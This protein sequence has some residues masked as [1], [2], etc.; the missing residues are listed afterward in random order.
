MFCDTL[1]ISPV[2][3]FA[4]K[5]AIVH[6]DGR[7]SSDKLTYEQLWQEIANVSRVVREA[8]LSKGERV[9]FVSENHLHWLPIFL[10]IAGA[11]AIAVPVDG[12]IAAARYKAIMADCQPA[13]IIVSRRFESRLGEFDL[14]EKKVFATLN[15]HF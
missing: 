14:T 9:L 15:L 12:N 3:E 1:K 2:S 5:D 4:G 13:L 6:D 11:G 7:G 10:G 8:G